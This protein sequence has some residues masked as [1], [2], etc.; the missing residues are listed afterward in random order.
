MR[1]AIAFVFLLLVSIPG[2]GISLASQDS[3]DQNVSN[4]IDA[5]RNH[6]WSGVGIIGESPTRW[7]FNFTAPMTEILACGSSAQE[8]LLAKLSDSAIWDQVIILL[9]G[10][11]DERAVGP[12]IDTLNLASS[13]L[14]SDRKKRILMAA[15]VALTNITVADVIWGHGG[16]IVINHCPDEPAQCWSGWWMQNRETFRANRRTQSRPYEN[17]PNYGIYRGLP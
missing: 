14:P 4:L 6:P 12:I 13:E 16:G 8:A 5:L 9:G 15:N 17:Y 10:V 3:T 11:G 7:D 1:R 2:F